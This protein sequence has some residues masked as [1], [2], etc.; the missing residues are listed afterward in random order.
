M[1]CTIFR[2]RIPPNLDLPSKFNLLWTQW[3][4]LEYLLLMVGIP[5]GDVCGVVPYYADELTVGTVYILPT[6]VE[7]GY[8]PHEY[9][10]TKEL[11][12]Q[13]NFI[14]FM[15]TINREA[16][17]FFY[18]S[19]LP[20]HKCLCQYPSPQVVGY[21][22]LSFISLITVAASIATTLPPSI[23]AMCIHE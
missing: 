14:T 23:I 20:L 13:Q 8:L 2:E 9:L 16:E 18:D 5:I 12:Y 10:M 11:I 1:T 19:L 4:W 7:V 3:I 21:C 22:R 15:Y 6:L 17:R